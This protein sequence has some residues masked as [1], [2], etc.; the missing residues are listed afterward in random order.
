MPNSRPKLSQRER[1]EIFLLGRGRC[2]VCK[3]PILAGQPWEADHIKPRWLDGPDKL[4][5]M[6]PIHLIPCHRRKSAGETK[7]RAKIKRIRNKLAGVKKKW[8]R[9]I[10]SRPFPKR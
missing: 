1:A 8:T 7:A 6:R 4:E 9:K 10:P 2:H 5:N 3:E